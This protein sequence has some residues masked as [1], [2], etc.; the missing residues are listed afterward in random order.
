MAIG[1]GSRFGPYELVSL[2]G[3]GGMGEVYRAHDPRLRRDVAL[4]VLLS[5]PVADADRLRRFQQE[6]QATSQL[7]HPNILTLYDVGQQDGIPYIVSELLEGETLRQRL[8]RERLPLRRT[9]E[10]GIQIARGLAAAHERGIIHRDLKPENIFVTRDGHS[11]ILDFG[12]AKLVSG[13]HAAQEGATLTLKTEAGVLLGTVGYL[14]PEQAR[15]LPSDHRTDVFSFGAILYEMATGGRAFQGETAADTMAKVLTRD[16]PPPSESDRRI[17]PELDRIIL[18]A[19]E[20]TPDERF[21]TMR[22]AVFALEGIANPSSAAA[23]AIVPGASAVARCCRL[24][25]DGGSSRATELSLAAAS[26]TRSQN[27]RTRDP[28]KADGLCRN[29]RVPGCLTR[30]QVCGFFGGRRGAA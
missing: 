23:A 21:Q 26:G 12:L 16:P 30:R 8:T 13:N 22:D 25:G 19:L 6:A 7:N 3:A 5:S 11:K 17:P 9:I 27:G 2:L 28:A 14:S 10:L 1:A 24:T 29:G 18:H 20:K 15:G 4:K